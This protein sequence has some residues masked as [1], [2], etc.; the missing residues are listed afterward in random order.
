MTLA[1]YFFGFFSFITGV[2]VCTFI[3][4]FFLEIVT[5]KEK[6]ENLLKMQA[7]EILSLKNG[8]SNVSLSI[9]QPESLVKVFTLIVFVVALLSVFIV[10][11]TIINNILNFNPLA[12]LT[13][14]WSG[15]KITP[16]VSNEVIQALLS[17]EFALINRRLIEFDK[18]KEKLI[19]CQ[20][21]V[22]TNCSNLETKLIESLVLIKEDS[23]EVKELIFNSS[24]NCCEILLKKNE[25][26]E[27]L[28][29]KDN[30]S[31]LVEQ[32]KILVIKENLQ[33]NLKLDKLL[34]EINQLAVQNN[35]SIN[36][37]DLNTLINTI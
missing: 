14:W 35:T 3:Y 31:A 16:P 12:I 32:T 30:T 2:P 37:A 24:K 33:L 23:S 9:P 22:M 10:G 17:F 6:L 26:L 8:L 4:N 7:N 19:L 1:N 20:E 11:S 5:Q 21:T 34:L 28:F 15:S 13:N 25:D 27:D 36:L 29:I 18:L